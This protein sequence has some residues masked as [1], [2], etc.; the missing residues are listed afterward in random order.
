M[1]ERAPDPI[2]V[3]PFDTMELS[4]LRRAA[5]A[6][7]TRRVGETP[8]RIAPEARAPSAGDLVLA[9]IDTL[10]YHAGLQLPNGRRRRLFAGDE[11]VV[12]YGNRYAPNQ[13]EA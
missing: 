11:I 13:F 6:S 5:W 1:H 4:R 7:T 9:R 2:D 12:A 8:L 10:G 3:L